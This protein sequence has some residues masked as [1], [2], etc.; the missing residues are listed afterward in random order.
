RVLGQTLYASS[1]SYLGVTLPGKGRLKCPH[2]H[3]SGRSDATATGGD[4]SP[5]DECRD[6]ALGGWLSQKIGEELK[7]KG[8]SAA[9]GA[10]AGR[11]VAVLNGFFNGGKRLQGPYRKTTCDDSNSFTVDTA[12]MS[13]FSSPRGVSVLPVMCSLHVDTF[14]G[15]IIGRGTFCETF[16]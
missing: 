14:S 3:T 6:R 4:D 13:G 12:A 15:P 2:H 16:M 10:V 11:I 9:I 8:I 1:F 7:M 5:G